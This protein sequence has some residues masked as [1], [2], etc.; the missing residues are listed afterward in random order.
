MTEL[1]SRARLDEAMGITATEEQ[2]AAITAP[3]TPG[4]IV[5]GAGSGKTTSMAARVAWLVGSGLVLPDRVLGLTFTTK[6]A[7]QLLGAMRSA[8]ASLGIEPIEES[9]LGDPQV[10][11]YNAFGAA[12]VNEHAMRLG[13]EPNPTLLTPGARQQLAFHVVC[14][15]EVDLSSLEK[16]PVQ[17]TSY[18]L[19]LD[20]QLSELSITPDELVAYEDRTIEYLTSVGTLQK[21]GESML[22]T[23]GARKAL[24]QVINEWR[25]VKA[26][27]DLIDYSDQI[28]LAG[29][30]VAGF[31]DVREQ[32]A[33]RFDVVLLDEYQDTSIGQRKLLQGIFGSGAAVT[34]V[35]DP[36]QA[37]YGWRGASVANIDDFLVHFTG[38]RSAHSAYSLSQ[39]RRS[40]PAILELANVVS[41]DLRAQHDAVR[42]L[43][44]GP[45]DRGPGLVDIGLFDT[46]DDELSWMCQRIREVHLSCSDGESVA[47]L[48]ATGAD[49]AQI[50]RLLRDLGVPTQLAGAA[51]LLAQPAVIDVRAMLEVLHDPTANPA[52]LRIAAGPRWR[53]GPRDLAALGQRAKD[54]ARSSGRS[55]ATDVETALADAVVG[56]DPVEIV[57]LSDALFDLGSAELYSLEAFSRFNALALEISALR[58]AADLPLVDRI[59]RVI[60]TT[61]VGVEAQVA[62]AGDDTHHRSLSAFIEFAAEFTELDGRVTLGAFLSRLKDAERFDADIEFASPR[63]PGAVQ[64]LTVHKAKGLEFTHV[65]FPHLAAGAFPNGVSSGN[66]TT[67][68]GQVPWPLREDCPPDLA[69]F[70]DWVES[71][72]AKDHDA[73][74]ELLKARSEFDVDRLGYVAITRAEKS[75]TVTSHWWGGTQ[76]KPRGPHRIFTLIAEKVR[77]L[78]AVSDHCRIV[79]W[80][81]EPE[82]G[83]SN[84]LI[85]EIAEQYLPWP[86][87]LDPIYEALVQTAAGRV[88]SISAVPEPL[89]ESDE[90]LARWSL[91]T[92]A[93]TEESKRRFATEHVVRLGASVGASTFLRAMAEP[94]AL[95]RDLARPMPRK[96]SAAAQRGTE[97]HAWVEA[98][99]GQQSLL[100][101]DDLPGA[102]DDHIATDAELEALKEAFAETEFARLVPVAVERSFSIVIGGRV[103]SGRI[104]A[105]FEHDGR[106]D[107]I[108]WKTGSAVS[109]DPLQLALYRLAWS[110]IAGV[111]WRDVDA[112][113]VMVATGEV[114]RPATDG[115]IEALLILD[116]RSV[117]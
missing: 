16:S 64:L 92:A 39:N 45:Q 14:R 4:V 88:R 113:F 98:S 81:P 74:R 77:E 102:A 37:I 63:I 82:V 52:F 7:A 33:S 31:S 87:P 50:D 47:V 108:D 28:R 62:D 104:D 10:L 13:R 105:V 110:R 109:T 27:R 85:R 68:L 29:E 96:P 71:P 15:T 116:E 8:V 36:C 111:D 59:A 41:S 84:P 78:A 70:P 40:G 66:W 55:T 11:T 91:L 94:D 51:A 12:I 106:F 97:W 24:A 1:L 43:A 44:A 73:Y 67:S 32:V 30:L 99:F 86:A 69:S 103:V 17:V 112:G 79:S 117:V 56:G 6:A 83:A 26:D 18:L 75:L 90:R 89:I 25:A 19:E 65:F 5:A 101:P 57:S 23:A 93:L 53:I 22:A 38:S 114:I 58:T 49:L 20:D 61:G 3:L 9:E 115:D 76:V 48:G 107:V 34:A 35:G 80:S 95:A 72:R 100:D 46:I 54:I 2:W 21:I 42:E 60:R